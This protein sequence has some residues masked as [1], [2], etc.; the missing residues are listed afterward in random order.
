M[1]G[2]L[3]ADVMTPEKWP[4]PHSWVVFAQWAG[5]EL[6]CSLHSSLPKCC[7]D[8]RRITLL[9]TSHRYMTLSILVSWSTKTKCVLLLAQIPR[10]TVTDCGVWRCSMIAEMPGASEAQI[11]SIS[12]LCVCSMVNSFS[13]LKTLRFYCWLA[14]RLMSYVHRW[15]RTS[16]VPSVR[17]WAFWIL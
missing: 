16:L 2:G 6:C 9:S 17:S 14:A 15:S 4:L 8:H 10:H 12:Q 5:A 7:W 1:Y 3:F 11:L 13:P